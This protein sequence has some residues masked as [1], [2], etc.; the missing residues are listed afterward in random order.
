VLE[1]VSDSKLGS[2]NNDLVR[3]DEG[4]QEETRFKPHL[5]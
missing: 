2:F 4:F 3:E 5:E 1:L